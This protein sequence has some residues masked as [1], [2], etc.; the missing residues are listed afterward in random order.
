MN[1]HYT[2][3][4][5]L[6][7]DAEALVNT[8]NCVGVMGRGIALQF[9]KA[10]P[11]NFT[12]YARACKQGDVA[13]GKMLVHE[14]GRLGNP[15]FIIN[16]PTKRHWRGT[17]RLEWIREGLDDL[18]AVVAERGIASLAMPPLGCGLG[19]LDWR[20]VRPLIA[21]AAERMGN[22]S[23]IV[24]EPAGAPAP[25]AIA[26]SSKRPSM[27]PGRASLITL[28]ERYLQG[29]LDPSVTLLEVHKLMYFLQV[30]GEN[31]RLTYHKAP[32]GPY[33][34]ELR[35]VLNA[36]EGHYLLGYGDGGDSPSK[37]LEL[38]PGAADQARDFLKAS[39][40]TLRRLATL[41]EFVQGFESPSALELLA[42][43]HWLANEVGPA[44]EDSLIEGFRAWGNKEERFPP[45]QVEVAL[46]RLQ[47]F[48][49]LGL[50]DTPHQPSD[51]VA[52]RT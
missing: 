19:G 41:D 29:G 32:H 22:V 39:E 7:T 38:M 31:L 24:F 23:V 17:S 13:I 28:I 46:E 34:D 3:G 42:S 48:D 1:I 27:T 5:I 21:A 11:A 30:L 20:D 8:V 36:L 47:D 15:R 26:R 50:G 33:A 52:A 10:F 40:A 9:K 45:H 44:N 37:E 43:L 49:W 4:D 35:H 25:E 18:I 12:A 2:R 14:T 51:V 6:A 16:F